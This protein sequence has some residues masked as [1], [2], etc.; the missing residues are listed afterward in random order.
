MSNSINVVTCNISGLKDK[1]KR[2]AV[3]YWLKEKDYDIIFLQETHCHSKQEVHR[4][5][6]EWNGQ[7]IWSKGTNRSKGVAVLF[8]SKY[9][10]D[11]TNESIDNN[12][13]YIVFNLVVGENKYRFINVYTPNSEYERV[14]FINEINNWIDPEIETLIAGDFNCTFDSKLDRKNCIGSRDIGQIDLKN[15]LHNQNLDDVWRRRFPQ[16]RVF[17]WS[18]GNK[19]SRIDFWLVSK[20]L[21]DQVKTIE[22][23]SCV[24]SDHK[25]V[26][27]EFRTS[28]TQRGRGIWKMNSSVIESELF[29]SSF[30]KLWNVW[31]KEKNKYSDIGVWW[32]L[33]KHKIKNL[34]TWCSYK[35]R[36]DQN[37]KINCLEKQIELLENTAG[38]NKL[39]EL[40]EARSK[41]EKIIINKA[42]GA[43]IRS[44]INWYEYGEKSSKYFHSLEKKNAKEK[45][46]QM[47]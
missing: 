24:F 47:A 32:D 9:K 31:K 18:R 26:R 37:D 33:G 23:S 16:K 34:T 13:R 22:Y 14:K 36:I 35:L 28:E 39:S 3:F 1:K 15:L 4:W 17:S 7:C 19:A 41:L 40:Y 12:G 27:L 2:Q 6:Q 25:I 45:L 8:N 44:R 38:G 46:S 21:N 11:V 30:P 10:Y 20:S 42:E 5:S 29:N 43:K